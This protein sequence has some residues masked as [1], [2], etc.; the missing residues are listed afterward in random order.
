M[1]PC[2]KHPNHFF[3]DLAFFHEHLEYFVPEDGLQLFEFQR[4]RNA[5][6]SSLAIDVVLSLPK[7]TAIGQEDV[8]VG[9]ETEKVA[10]G[11]DS[12]DRAGDGFLFRYGLLDKNLQGIVRA[13]RD[14]HAE[15][16]QLLFCA[17][18]GQGTFME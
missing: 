14:A 3:G 12:N 17:A 7:E 5:K 16:R 13:V 9:I 11:L 18:G 15:L 6:H 1:F 4:R 10:E 8:A 2:G